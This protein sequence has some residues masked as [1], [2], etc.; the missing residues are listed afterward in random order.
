MPLDL[1]LVANLNSFKQIKGIIQLFSTHVRFYGILFC[2]L[3][4]SIEPMMHDLRDYWRQSE[5]FLLKFSDFLERNS[6]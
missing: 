5:D 2:R 3:F 6:E 1:L 4:S